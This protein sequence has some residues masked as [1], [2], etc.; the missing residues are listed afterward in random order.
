MSQQPD[1]FPVTTLDE[2]KQRKAMLFE[3]RHP[4]FGKHDIALFWDGQGAYALENS[5]PHLF[6]SLAD[7]RILPG[8][9]HCPLHGA[10]FSLKTG[11]CLDRFTLDV[12][13]YAARVD[14]DT[15]SIVAPG[16]T[17]G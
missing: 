14:G 13:A 10:Q 15:V 7:G 9:V 12:A 8:E 6:G 17:R 2:L 1:T 3:F 16:E 5:C 4:R 11:E